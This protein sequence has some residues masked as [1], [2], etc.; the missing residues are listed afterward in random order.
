MIASSV[1]IL[2]N[3]RDFTADK[4]VHELT[5]LGTPVSRLNIEDALSGRSPQSWELE[6][7]QRAVDLGCIWWRQFVPESDPTETIEDIQATLVKR[8]QW[9]SWISVLDKPG[10]LWVNPLWNARR[11]E[12]KVIQLRSAQSIGFLIPPTLITNNRADAR[13]FAEQY[14]KVIVKSLATAYYEFTDSSFVF[15]S[16]LTEDLLSEPASEWAAQPLILQEGLD[17]ER[18]VRIVYLDGQTFG[19]RA[20][21]RAVDWRRVSGRT[22]WNRFRV[23]EAIR[24]LCIEYARLLGLRYAAFDFLER[25]GNLYFLEANQAGEWAFLDHVHSGDITSWLANRLTALASGMSLISFEEADSGE[26][27]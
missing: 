14:D 15:T 10:I 17:G 16:E 13:Q 4:V 6:S 24:T 2:T 22:D 1:L 18:E 8:R 9:S 5:E 12:N 25:N 7:D 3:K 11:A 19:A 21:R 23:P 27:S 26:N 20:E